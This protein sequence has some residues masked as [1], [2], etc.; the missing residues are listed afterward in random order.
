MEA[1]E[2]CYCMFESCSGSTFFLN[3]FYNQTLYKTIAF[4]QD[5]N[6]QRLQF[7]QKNTELLSIPHGTMVAWWNCQAGYCRFK[8]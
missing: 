3:C 6:I 7:S 1:Q 5:L 2:P 8:P 4:P